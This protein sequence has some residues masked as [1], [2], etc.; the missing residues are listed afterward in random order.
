ML[1]KVI[2][3]LFSLLVVSPIFA[4]IE[5]RDTTQ[6]PQCDTIIDKNGLASPVKI[7]AVTSST[8]K[9]TQC[10]DQSK[11]IYTIATS[12]V[13][14]IKSKTFKFEKPVPV[15]LEKK[16]RKGLVFSIGTALLFLSSMKLVFDSDSGGGLFLGLTMLLTPFVLVGLLIHALIL[17]KKA[18]KAGDKKARELTTGTFVVVILTILLAIRI[19]LKEN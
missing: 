17:R 16:A 2:I 1:K 12:N 7:M 13:Q 14:D 15:T 19:F 3:S 18:K 4:V 8:I 6:I 11:R 5:L 10:S 9:Y